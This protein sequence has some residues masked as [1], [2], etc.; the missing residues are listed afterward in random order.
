MLIIEG[1]KCT[2]CTKIDINKIYLLTYNKYDEGNALATY[3]DHAEEISTAIITVNNDPNEIGIVVQ[4]IID[5]IIDENYNDLI[6]A[7]DKIRLDHAET[8]LSK[9]SRSWHGYASLIEEIRRKDIVFRIVKNNLL[10][11]ARHESF[12]SLGEPKL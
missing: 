9:I 6:A 1:I 7:V 11:Y 10:T 2:K 3:K 4:H 12:Y 5:T 8:D